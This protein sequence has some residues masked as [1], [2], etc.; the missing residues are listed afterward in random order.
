MLEYL[1]CAVLLCS[2]RAQQPQTQAEHE[3][4][5]QDKGWDVNN[6]PGKSLSVAIDVTEGTWMSIDVAPN[7]TEL[8]FDLL[9]DLYTLPIDGGE[10]KQ[11]TEGMAWDMQ[12]R[13]SPDG[14]RIAFTSDRGGGDNL[15]IVNSDGTSPQSSF[16]RSCFR[17][18]R[19]CRAR[20]ECAQ[21]S[22]GGAAAPR[23]DVLHLFSSSTKTNLTNYV[24][25]KIW[26]HSQS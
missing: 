23:S 20:T 15:W 24:F 16:L 3:D 7:G 12:P 22:E 13:Y 2:A 19:G 9:G 26:P 10:A 4:D 11:L 25:Q 5:A 18:G 1:L 17:S 14:K 6:P 8:V 21:V